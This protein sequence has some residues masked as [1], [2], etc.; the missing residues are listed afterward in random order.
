MLL[1]NVGEKKIIFSSEKEA[2]S[3]LFQLQQIVKQFKV[4]G[5]AFKEIDLRYDKPVV[6]F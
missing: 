6:R 3:Q 5:R 4:E 1:F 2:G